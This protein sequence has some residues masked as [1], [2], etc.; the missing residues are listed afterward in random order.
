MADAGVG[1]AA[2]AETVPRQIL[3]ALAVGTTTVAEPMDVDKV[4]ETMAAAAVVAVVASAVLY[5]RSLRKAEVAALR[6]MR[7]GATAAPTRG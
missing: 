5:R 6:R 4:A 2:A 3:L 1:T 7:G